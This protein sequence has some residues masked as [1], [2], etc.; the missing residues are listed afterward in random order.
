M[1]RGGL[2]MKTLLG[3]KTIKCLALIAAIAVIAFA[4]SAVTVYA[5]QKTKTIVATEK[6]KK[7]AVAFWTKDRIKNTP[8][9]QMPVDYGP[10]VVDAAVAGLAEEVLDPIIIPGGAA[11][12]DADEVAKEAYRRDWQELE[13]ELALE[14]TMDTDV[15]EEVGTP[16]IYT[17]WDYNSM[18]PMNTWY[19]HR[20][21]GRLSFSTPTGTGYCSATVIKNNY[22]VTAAHCVY[23]TAANRFYTNWV[24]IPA[25]KNGSA[26]YGTFSWTSA[27]VLNTWINLSGSYSINNWARYDVAI[28]KLGNNSAG[29]TVNSMV[30]Y[31]GYGINWGYNN[32]WFNSGYPWRNFQLNTISYPGAYQRACIDEGFQQATNVVGG[33]CIWGSGISGGSWLVSYRPNISTST[34]NTAPNNIGSVNSG[35]FVGVDNLYGGIF[36]SDNIGL[37]CSGRCN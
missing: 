4:A 31:M 8:A 20:R 27:T 15:D 34:Y 28:I 17:Y 21:V 32:L 22:I 25:Y 30:G 35:L 33:G 36:R 2:Q 11:D 26:P 5:A 24:F 9:F 14:Q 13:D 29:R 10:N 6:Q 23:D 3:R 1:L 7:D 18:S 12:A 16:R 19:P 37:L